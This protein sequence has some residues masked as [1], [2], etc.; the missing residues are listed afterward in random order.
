MQRV[1][2]AYDALAT[3]GCDVIKPPPNVHELPLFVRATM[4]M[5]AAIEQVIEEHAREG[6][7]LYIWRDGQVVAVP[8]EE[9]RKK[10]RSNYRKYFKG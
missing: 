10:S 4:A 2:G 7:P 1:A 8:A 6:L 5:E 3:R 9:F